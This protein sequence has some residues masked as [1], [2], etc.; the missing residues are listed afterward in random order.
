[1]IKKKIQ[2]LTRHGVKLISVGN[3]IDRHTAVI[4]RGPMVSS[5]LMQLLRDTEWGELDYLFI[6]LPPGTGDIQLTMAKKIPI[7]TSVIVTTPQ[8]LSLIDVER[9]I[10]MFNKVDVHILGI[11]ENMNVYTCEHCG[12]VSHI[13]GKF[14]EDKLSNNHTKILGRIPLVSEVSRDSDEGNP[15]TIREDNT[16]ISLVYQQVALN[17]SSEIMMIPRAVNINMPGIKVEYNK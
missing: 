16:S 10:A 9:A 4:W 3:L 7:T 17:V 1:M 6:D 14:S 5:A 13:F 8:D 12:G 15:T 2:P 11:I